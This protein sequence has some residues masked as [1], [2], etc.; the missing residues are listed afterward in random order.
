MLGIR[1]AVHF[2]LASGLKK[3]FMKTIGKKIIDEIVEVELGGLS[4]DP[5][6]LNG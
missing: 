6:V 5:P 4:R 1:R 2:G 3:R